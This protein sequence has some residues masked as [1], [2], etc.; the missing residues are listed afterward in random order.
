M[1]RF[2]SF[3]VT[4]SQVILGFLL[5]V[6]GS[7]VFWGTHKLLDN[8]K[9]SFSEKKT[10]NRYLVEYHSNLENGFYCEL[11]SFSTQD[12]LDK[13]VTN[14]KKDSKLIRELVFEDYDWCYTPTPEQK[15]DLR[16]FIL[17][18]SQNMIVSLE[19]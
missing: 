5:L 3:W 16:Y 11:V 2:K 14:S 13:Y 9:D 18:K 7:F 1:N 19:Y 8:A 6:L 15:A 10:M 12:E 4:S 17:Q